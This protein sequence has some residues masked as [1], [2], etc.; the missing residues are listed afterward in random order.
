MS[1]KRG[2]DGKR[3]YERSPKEKKNS[4]IR[5]EKCELF[6]DFERSTVCSFKNEMQQMTKMTRDPE[7]GPF[8]R[9]E[10]QIEMTTPSTQ[11]LSKCN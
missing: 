4:R 1:S 6:V 10:R 2:K 8:G 11:V 5:D 9:R 3:N 7:S